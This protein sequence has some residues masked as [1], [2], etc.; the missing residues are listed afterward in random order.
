MG[1]VHNLVA[2]LRADTGSFDKKINKSRKNMTRFGKD[3]KSMGK[4]MLAV[5]GVSGGFFALKRGLVSSIRAFAAFEK[6]GAMVSTML[7]DQTMRF[8]PEFT[9]GIKKL[10]VQ[11]GESTD[12]LSKGLFDILS[13]SVAPQKAMKVLTASVKAAKAG[14]TTT[15]VAADA[16]TTVLNSYGLEADKAIFVSDKLFAIVKRGKTTFGELAPNIGKVAAI[17]NVAGLSLDE[18][19][20]AIATMTR[21]GLQ[22]EIAITSLRSVLTAFI[23]PTTEA[24]K[25]AKAFGLELS[26]STLRSIGLSGALKL[27]SKATAEQL[28]QIIPNVRGMAGFATALKQIE[29]HAEDM[30]IMINSAGRTEEAFNKVIGTTSVKLEILTQK[31]I[32]FKVA[33]GEGI[34]DAFSLPSPKIP[35]FGGGFVSGRDGP[36]AKGALDPNSPAGIMRQRRLD[37]EAEAKALVSAAKEFQSIQKTNAELAMDSIETFRIRDAAER[38]TATEISKPFLDRIS[39]EIELT[40]KVGDARQHAAKAIDLQNKLQAKGLEGTIAAREETKKLDAALE[41]LSE[42][43]KLQR[44]AEDIGS[45]FADAFTDMIFEAK[46]FGDAMKA[47]M[48]DISRSIIRNLITKPLGESISAGIGGIFGLTPATVQHSGGVVGRGGPTRNVSSGVFAG[49]PRLHNGLAGDEFPAILQRGETVTPRGGGGGNAPTIIINNNTGQRMRQDG[50]AQFNGRD[51]IIGIVA[52]DIEN[53]GQLR[54]LVGGV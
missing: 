51:M 27:L 17:A 44:I 4:Q 10:S 13:A 22:T 12:T 21:G 52:D 14:F 6:Q 20:A 48:R 43:Q 41:R 40:G 9:K 28:A 54:N 49:A 15:A 7:N 8:M 31:W 42:A 32:A 45:A 47:L 39:K 23:S 29:G 37:A 1:M 38:K 35:D 5:A 33:V 30:E 53:G 16:I 26:S 24:I 18:L 36:V 11:F 34:V 2:R 25:A 50:P 19:G 46:R 3:V